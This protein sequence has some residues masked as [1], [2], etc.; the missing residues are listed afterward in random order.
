MILPLHNKWTIIFYALFGPILTIPF[1]QLFT[2]SYQ[3]NLSIWYGILSINLFIGIS[4]T[5]ALLIIKNARFY[6]FIRVFSSLSIALP[7]LYATLIIMKSNFPITYLQIFISLFFI[8]TVEWFLSYYY[9]KIRLAK[10]LEKKY[11]IMPSML[12]KG[13]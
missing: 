3:S 12:T 1:A 2:Y 6:Y 5:A 9:Q 10:A 7:C 4:E 8:M 13:L 11:P